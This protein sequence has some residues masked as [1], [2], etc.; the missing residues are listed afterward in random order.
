MVNTNSPP[1]WS[2]CRSGLSATILTPTASMGVE[3]VGDCEHFLEG[4][5]AA[6]RWPGSSPSFAPTPTRPEYRRPI[7][8]PQRTALRFAVRRAPG[9][10]QLRPDR[11]RSA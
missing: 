1:P 10:D 3:V 5:T 8:G 4:A 6:D 11:L 2:S 9:P 7:T